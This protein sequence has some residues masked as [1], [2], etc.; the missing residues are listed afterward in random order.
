VSTAISQELR[1]NLVEEIKRKEVVVK[2][3]VFK[4]K[5]NNS[6]LETFER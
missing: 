1:L 2:E 3:S 5:V 4:C 6:Y